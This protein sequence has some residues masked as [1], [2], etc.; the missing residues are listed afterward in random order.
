MEFEWDF[1]DDDFGAEDNVFGGPLGRTLRPD[2]SG[3]G[4][5]PDEGP[6]GPDGEEL[7]FG[8]ASGSGFLALLGVLFVMERAGAETEIVD[9]E[10]VATAGEGLG[11]G[12][13]T[14]GAGELRTEDDLLEFPPAGRGERLR[15]ACAFCL[16]CSGYLILTIFRA[17][18]EG[19]SSAPSESRGRFGGFI[20]PPVDFDTEPEPDPDF[21][22]EE[23]G[24]GV[25]ETGLGGRETGLEGK[26][27]GFGVE[28]QGFDADA[29]DFVRLM[30]T[31]PPLLE[32][33]AD[34]EAGVAA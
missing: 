26:E 10:V 12:R 19:G 2:E 17:L 32:A 4:F 30:R 29:D 25:E 33:E 7:C 1:E 9:V 34:I 13:A 11:E 5:L 27:L 15:I 31:V 3:S 14:P 22:I 6:A 8:T 24:F 21:D 23:L 20:E 16:R 28:N 18:L